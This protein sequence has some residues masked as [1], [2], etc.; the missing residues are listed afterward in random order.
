MRKKLSAA[1]GLVTISAAGA[2]IMSS[3]AFAEGDIASITGAPVVAGPA[4]ATAGQAQSLVA[5]ARTVTRDE[6]RRRYRH[7][8]HRHHRRHHRHHRHHRYHHHRGW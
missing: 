5:N 2:L 1:A 7:R 8:R 4:S 3:P 6:G